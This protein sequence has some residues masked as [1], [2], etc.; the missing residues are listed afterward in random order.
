MR[1]GAC[2]SRK[3]DGVKYKP[4]IRLALILMGMYLVFQCALELSTFA[5]Y[6]V[7]ARLLNSG[8]SWIS[9]GPAW[10]VALS[11]ARE[12]LQVALGLYLIFGGRWIVHRLA[13]IADLD[14]AAV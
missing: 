2:D 5:G 8:T 11:L 4:L 13:R 6:L 12:G 1:H 14:D 10:V 9:F 7:S 3:R